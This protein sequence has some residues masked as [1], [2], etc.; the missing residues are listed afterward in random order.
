MFLGEFYTTFT[1]KG[2]VILPKKMRNM[3]S[4]KEII[5]SRGFERCI[6][7][8]DLGSFEKEAN[9]QLEVSSAEKSA[10]YIRRYIFS[11]SVSVEFDS[12]GR[13]VIPSVL[14]TYAHLKSKVVVIGAGD[15]FEVWDESNWKKHLKEVE[16][17]YGR[18]S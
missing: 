1:G 8:Y 11:G 18:V 6:F 16:G 12:Q 14:L 17:D 2:R 13:F 4:G 5:L 10:R 9:K 15:H 7:G 3:I